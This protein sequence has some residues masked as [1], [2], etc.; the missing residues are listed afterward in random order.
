MPFFDKTS[1]TSIITNPNCYLGSNIPGKNIEKSFGLITQVAKGINGNIND[2]ME[3]M[4]DSFFNKAVEIGADAVI[5]LK[6]ENGSYQ[7]NGSGWVVSYLMI[8]GEAVLTK[9][10]N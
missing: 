8:Y 10:T 1:K 2:K 9:P 5:N 4:M 7:Q 6:F 3:E